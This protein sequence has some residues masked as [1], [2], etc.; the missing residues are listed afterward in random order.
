MTLRARITLVGISV[1]LLVALALIITSQVSQQ[2]IE[3]RFAS[4]TIN[5][6][7]ALWKK[8]IAGQLQAMV[9]GTTNLSRDRSTRKALKSGDNTTLAESAKTTF[10]L[11]SAEKILTRMQIIN[12]KH[13]VV[14]SAPNY[15]NGST[16]KALFKQ[17][18]DSGKI[19]R[20]L[21]RDDDGKL[22]A[23]IAF[24]LFM[25]GKVIGVGI[26]LKDLNTAISDFKI[27]DNSEV[28]IVSAKGQIEYATDKALYTHLNITLPK[29]GGN[30]VG[31]ARWNKQVFSSAILPITRVDGKPLAHLITVN[32][33]TQSYAT[34]TNFK[35]MAYAITALVLLVAMLGL[36]YYM[37]H[38]LNPLKG[39]VANLQSIAD[40]DLTID[41]DVRTN[42]EIGQ[43]KAAMQSMV[44][45]L[46]MMVEKINHIT[47]QLSTSST[48][49]HNV[50]Q[51]TN[52]NVNKQQSGL[53]YI[54]TAMNEM[55]STVQEVAHNASQAAAAAANADNE[56]RAGFALVDDTIKSIDELTSEV[57][58]TSTVINTLKDNS[59]DISGI[60]DVIRG[61]AEQT[62]LL[63]LNAAIE[64]ARAGEHGR[65][66]AVVADEVRTLSGRTQESA[67]ETSQMIIQ[68]QQGSQSAVDAMQVIY[69]R[70]QET[71][72]K[73]A[74]AGKSLESIT[75]A[76]STI[77]NMNIQIASAAEEQS[78]V[79]EEINRNIVDISSIAEMTAVGAENTAETSNELTA[80]SV[81]LSEVVGR[82]K[83]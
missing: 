30:K 20:G 74:D 15:Y 41:I 68:L 71:V 73:A 67:A 31:V 50:T 64:A 60:L 7:A 44:R 65:G 32:D 45:Q 61:I 75:Q 83:I 62:N 25:R 16:N 1:T 42:D 10:N 78:S 29:L 33:F 47:G 80:L 27:N 56:S 58:N 36:F 22:I 35:R 38:V 55:T 8:I 21:E 14:F 52:S 26:Y 17:A 54:A 72:N 76:V 70:A 19:I 34:Q 23:E 49:M 3:N 69:T 37:K 4:A 66:F 43:L 5:G 39:A 18:L 77:N 2:Q 59:E 6:K 11:L 9:V 81:H 53:E 13:E 57:K 40:G 24:P 48:S 79:A 46:N 51:E 12:L 28:F 82:F 63:A